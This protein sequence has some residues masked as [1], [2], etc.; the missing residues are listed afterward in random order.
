[1]A[2]RFDDAVLKALVRRSGTR[3]VRARRQGHRYR[4]AN[5]LRK[6]AGGIVTNITKAGVFV[7]ENTASPT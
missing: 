4:D 1:V 7:R 2:D 3:A 5:L 6:L